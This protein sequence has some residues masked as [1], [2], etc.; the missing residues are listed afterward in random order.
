MTAHPAYAPLTDRQI[1]IL[2]AWATVAEEERMGVRLSDDEAWDVLAS[3][4]TGVFT[5]LRA[6]GFPVSLPVWF[7]VADREVWISGAASTYK[8]RRVRRDNRVS[9]LVE[10]GLKW[11]ELR[12]VQ[13]TGRAV[14]ESAPDWARVDTL[15]DAKYR[16]FRTPRPD[17]PA[18]ARARYD[19]ARA[20]L[21]L[22]PDGDL[23]TWDNARLEGQ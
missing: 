22:R 23:L 9:F 16:D 12:A 3:S 8:F 15:F 21:R 1:Q 4:H 14:L 2:G 18:S 20:L 11:S 10:S 13:F 6:D 7:V 19:A 5:S 17:M